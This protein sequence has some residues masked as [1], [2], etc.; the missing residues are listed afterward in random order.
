M[1]DL[2]QEGR[3]IQ[4]LFRKIVLS[5]ALN[6][7]IRKF[8]EDINKALQSGGFKTNLAP[9]GNK[10]V[11][12]LDVSFNDMPI[13]DKTRMQKEQNLVLITAHTSG[14]S[15]DDKVQNLFVYC[16]IK[17][18]DKVSKILDKFQVSEYE[19]PQLKNPITGVSKQVV[20]GF[21]PGD[22]YK[23]FEGQ[24]IS[25]VYYFMYSRS[26]QSETRIKTTKDGDTTSQR[27]SS[28]IFW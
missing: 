22:I 24:A 19:G 11:A 9:H 13:S 18:K 27:P 14:W 16:N 5:E 28:N 8:G 21:N 2:L 25:N 1:K 23:V 12:V 7:D 17:D 20:A 15:Q 4:E 6:K 26:T 3:R 10:N